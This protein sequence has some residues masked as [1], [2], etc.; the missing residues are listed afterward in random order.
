MWL[1]VENRACISIHPNVKGLKTAVVY[2]W[3]HASS[4]DYSLLPNIDYF[5]TEGTILIT[6]VSTS[7]GGK[8]TCKASNSRGYESSD[9]HLTVQTPLSLRL[10]PPAQ[11]VDVGKE[12]R[13]ECAYRGFPLK[14]VYWVKDGVQL[15][16]FPRGEIHKGDNVSTLRIHSMDRRD[17]GL[18]QCFVEG[19]SQILSQVSQ[20]DLGNSKANIISTFDHQVLQPGSSLS[21]SCKAT[22][23]PLPSISWFVDGRP[24]YGGV[25]NKTLGKDVFLSTLDISSISASEG[26][27]YS[28]VAENELGF[29]THGQRVD[30]YGPPFIKPMDPLSVL[31][32]SDVLIHCPYT[33]YPILQ[34]K[35][36][37]NG[38]ILPVNE[39]QRVFESNASLQ[40]QNIQLADKGEYTCTISNERSV[41]ARENFELS[42]AIP[43]KIEPF[44]FKDDLQVGGRIRVSCTASLGDLPIKFEWLFNSHRLL[45]GEHSNGIS[46]TT[47]DAFSSS[48]VIPKLSTGHSGNFTCVASNSAASDTF[49]SSLT[50]NELKLTDY[51][52]SSPT[53]YLFPSVYCLLPAMCVFIPEDPCSPGQVASI[54]FLGSQSNSHSSNEPLRLMDG[55]GLSQSKERTNVTP[56]EENRILS[57]GLSVNASLD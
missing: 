11:R 42:V 23:S 40:I 2:E 3:F 54:R 46:I 9:V 49:S 41:S 56:P 55:V 1:H 17:K 50:V 38:E 24:I 27:H 14:D 36:T 47:V 16:L 13:I 21:I 19:E 51:F 53:A 10:Y 57:H 6:R 45:E 8:W 52:Y 39:R 4:S 22:G 32:A 20:L 37:K 35:W 48:L 26:G 30:V 12:V 43:P 33:G 15:T 29:M 34:V 25:F 7:H 44:H 5:V 31:A 18:Y 28:C